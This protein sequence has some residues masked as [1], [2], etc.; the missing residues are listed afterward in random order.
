MDRYFSH[1]PT[2]TSCNLLI[3]NNDTEKI[4]FKRDQL[5]LFNR[6]TRFPRLSMPAC[7]QTPIDRSRQWIISR[8]FF[9]LSSL[10]LS[11][12]TR[13]KNSCNTIDLCPRI[14]PSPKIS[15]RFIIFE[16]CEARKMVRDKLRH[17]DNEEN[18]EAVSRRFYR[19]YSW[20]E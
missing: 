9:L 7:C 1:R 16:Q 15:S 11:L 12:V 4:N 6:C 13:A 2:F 18:G 19:F 20:H 10:S 17:V 5:S 14:Y 8:A 3:R